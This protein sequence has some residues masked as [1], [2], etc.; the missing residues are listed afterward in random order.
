[1]TS[2]YIKKVKTS[3]YLLAINLAERLNLPPKILNLLHGENLVT[4]GYV[5]SSSGVIPNNEALQIVSNWIKLNDRSTIA[6]DV[7]LVIE[8]IDT[9]RSVEDTCGGEFV[10]KSAIE[11]INEL[12][13]KYNCVRFEIE[14]T[15]T[16]QTKIKSELSKKAIR[17]A[18]LLYNL[19]TNTDLIGTLTNETL[20]SVIKSIHD[21]TFYLNANKLPKEC[22]GSEWTSSE[23][24]MSLYD[25]LIIAREMDLECNNN[26]SDSLFFEKMFFESC[27]RA[28]R[29]CPLLY[30][31]TRMMALTG[32]R[33]NM[34]DSKLF[35]LNNK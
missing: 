15:E 32:L 22:K 29:A 16:V 21:G 33:K 8:Y 14:E 35:D 3:A 34:T 18:E 17:E 2:G 11:T 5:K 31:S 19:A 4:M 20:L 24:T 26:N 6:F 27:V 30:K 9:I 25:F 7:C 28:Y 13:I 10:A 23:L 1:M 12:A